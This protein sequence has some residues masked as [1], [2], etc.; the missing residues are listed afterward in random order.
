MYEYAIRVLE[1]KIKDNNSWK[2]G[3]DYSK[4]NK[5]LQFAIST[6][7]KQIPTRERIIG[8]LEEY[9]ITEKGT[10]ILNSVKSEFVANKICEVE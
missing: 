7:K 10:K 2:T 1:D 5:E 6:L 3:S 9:S 4:E 8:V